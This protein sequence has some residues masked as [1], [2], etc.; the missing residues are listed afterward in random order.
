MGQA[1]YRCNKE[2]DFT[3]DIRKNVTDVKLVNEYVIFVLRI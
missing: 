3:H 2:K 1:K